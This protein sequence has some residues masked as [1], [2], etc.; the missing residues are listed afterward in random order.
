MPVCYFCNPPER[1]RDR[2][3]ERER[4]QKK[5]E[6]ESGSK[7]KKTEMILWSES[8]SSACLSST[9]NEWQ[10]L[11]GGLLTAAWPSTT[12]RTYTVQIYLGDT[13]LRQSPFD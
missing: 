1:E 9:P 12:N 13:V 2:E 10:M 4:E 3:S 6:I 7:E 11:Q 8:F 5:E